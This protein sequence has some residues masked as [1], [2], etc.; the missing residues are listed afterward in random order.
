ME[1]YSRYAI[2][3]PN[4][5]YYSITGCGWSSVYDLEYTDTF[6]TKQLCEETIESLSDKNLGDIRAKLV[7]YEFHESP[8]E[9]DEDKLEKYNIYPD[10]FNHLTGEE[11]E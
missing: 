11:D 3:G 4:G 2:Q 7:I 5:M 8:I 9:V 10:R 6:S 1:G